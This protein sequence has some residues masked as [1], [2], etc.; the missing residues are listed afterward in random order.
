MRWERGRERLLWDDGT[1]GGA[2]GDLLLPWQKA[3]VGF[4]LFG[5]LTRTGGREM[6]VYVSCGR[7]LERRKHSLLLCS[8]PPPRPLLLYHSLSY[9]GRFWH[10]ALMGKGLLRRVEGR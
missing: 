2:E 1:H 9:Q 3:S 4:F 7:S 5:R 8:P 10:A 6:Y